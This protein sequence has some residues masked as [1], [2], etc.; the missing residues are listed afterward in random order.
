LEWKDDFNFASFNAP[1]YAELAYSSTPAYINASGLAYF[2]ATN[3][4]DSGM[5]GVLCAFYPNTGMFLSCLAAPF[6]QPGNGEYGFAP[7]SVLHGEGLLTRNDT[8]IVLYDT[9]AK[10]SGRLS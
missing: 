7:Q 9:T 2:T 3:F 8:D 1:Y 5:N 10:R 4:T 6:T